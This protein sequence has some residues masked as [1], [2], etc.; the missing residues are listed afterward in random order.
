M[1]IGATGAPWDDRGEHV[2]LTVTE[3]AQQRLSDL[4]GDRLEGEQGIRI[5]MQAGGCGCS[6]PSFGM[7]LDEPSTADEVMTIG[8]LRFIVD[9]DS[10]PSLLG[11]SIDYVEDVMQ[12]GFAIEAPNAQVGGGC[13]CGGH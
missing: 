2:T 10:A 8:S 9:P 3:T 12:Q 13:G 4:I 7:G 6:G 1:Y 5:F 11:A